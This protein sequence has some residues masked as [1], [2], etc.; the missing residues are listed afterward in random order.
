MKLACL[1]LLPILIMD[2]INGQFICFS[3]AVFSIVIKFKEAIKN[4][5]I[6]VYINSSQS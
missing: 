3:L 2:N 6:S 4:L 5:L 1:Q